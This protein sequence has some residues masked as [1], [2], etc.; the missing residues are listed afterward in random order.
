MFTEEDALRILES[1][2]MLPK[3]ARFALSDEVLD[4]CIRNLKKEIAEKKSLSYKRA[5]Q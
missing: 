2:K 1:N 4:I 5:D 3:H